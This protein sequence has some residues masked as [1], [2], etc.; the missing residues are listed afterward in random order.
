M[1]RF[2]RLFSLLLALALALPFLSIQPSTP[3]HASA[4]LYVSGP[5][6]GVVGDTLTVNVTTDASANAFQGTFNYPSAIFEGVRGTFTGA[7]CSLPITVP[8]PSGGTTDFSCGKPSGFTGSGVVAT[9]ILK[10]IGDGSGS[11]G[12]SG[13][14]VLANDGQGTD[15]TGACSGKSVNM[16]AVASTPTPAATATPAA[17]TSAPAVAKATATP[18]TTPSPTPTKAPTPSGTPVPAETA[19]P[20]PATVAPTPP[21]VQVLSTPTPLPSTEASASPAATEATP[22]QRRTIAQAVQDILQSSKDL[23]KLGTSASGVV[24]LLIT[25]LPFL[26]MILAILF[27]IFR[28]YSMEHRRRRTLDRL[29]ELELAEMSALEG[30]LDLLS[31]KGTKGRDEYRAEFQRTKESILRQLKPTFNKP[32]ETPAEKS[33]GNEK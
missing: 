25:T 18:K 8:D 4:S 19:K 6:S 21:P 12:L 20:A 27:L 10:V 17:A 7:I 14:Q 33:A 23:S 11:I 32:I 1:R 2:P 31:E 3:A 26:A 22:Q 16:A 28:L 5:S 9:I 15:I 13:C 30:K 24:A 29:F